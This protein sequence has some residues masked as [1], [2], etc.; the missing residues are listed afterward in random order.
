M[1]QVNP[2]C[3]TGHQSNLPPQKIPHL[4]TTQGSLGNK[5]TKLQTKWR[6]WGLD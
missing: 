6:H 1:P 2:I 4:P 5:A 3:E